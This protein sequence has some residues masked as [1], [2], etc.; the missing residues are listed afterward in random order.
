MKKTVKLSDFKDEAI[1]KYAEDCLNMVELSEALHAFDLEEITEFIDT[2][3]GTVI[4]KPFYYLNNSIRISSAYEKLLDN[5]D[6][7][8]IEKIE[9]LIKDL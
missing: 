9:E 8:P 1:I 2:N 4:T 5:I 6:K 3:W 7:V